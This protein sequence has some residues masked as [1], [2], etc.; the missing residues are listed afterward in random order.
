MNEALWA[1]GRG[2]GIVALVM[3][4]ITLVLG[5]VTRS[6]RSVAG[7]GRFGVA[8]LHRTAALTGVGLVAVHVGSLLLRPVRP[9]PPGRRGL[10]V[11]R[12]LPAA[13][14]GPGH[15]G[16][17][18]AR[19]RDR[20]QPAAAPGRPA[21]LQVRALGSPTCCGRSPCSTPSATAPTPAR[22]GSA[23]RRDL[24]RRRVPRRR[25]AARSR[26]TRTAAGAQ[27]PRTAD[28]HHGPRRH[29]PAARAPEPTARPLPH[30]SLETLL[31][32]GRQRP[33]RPRRRG[34]PDRDQ[35]ARGRRR[36]RGPGRGRQ[37]AWRASR[38]AT[39]TRSCSTR[40]PHLV[41][42]RPGA[43]R[44][45]ARRRP[46]RPRGR[47]RDRPGRRRRG[48]RRRADRGGPARG[49]VRRRPG[50]RA[51]QPARRP[52]GVP[53]RPARAGH[54]VAASTDGRRWS[55]TPRPWPSWP[56]V[57]RHGAG[58]VPLGGHRRGPRHLAVHDQRRGP[59]HPGV[60]EAPRGTPL[61]RRPGLGAAGA[62][63]SPC[64][65]AATTAPGC[66]RRASTHR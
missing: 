66:R 23:P 5:I 42:R 55:S 63:R 50:V 2:T 7:L 25:L 1:L 39:R 10:P 62:T 64:W 32:R 59:T 19:R 14:A 36:R 46:G 11:P 21:R 41:R 43:G 44:A 49:R 16:P 40:N 52:A 9:A 28:D 60:V 31:A 8:D 34:L 30:L 12:Q 24:L 33:D 58:V 17:R 51:G 20:G 61:R 38:S 56:C 6:G 13:L 48:R 35:A 4:T 47:A 22:C 18:P 45:G 3:F 65:W 27:P 54:R 29:P 26:R 53:A 57:A 37:R 15:P